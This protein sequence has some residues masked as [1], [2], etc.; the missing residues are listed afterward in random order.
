MQVFI[1]TNIYLD[2]F[3]AQSSVGRLEPL[4]KLRQLVK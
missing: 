4:Q 1:D 2:Y 3:R